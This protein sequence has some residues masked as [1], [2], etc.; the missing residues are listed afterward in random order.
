MNAWRDGRVVSAEEHAAW[1]DRGRLLGHGV[2]S[3][4]L[5]RA[6][7]GL[8][9]E[10]H[11]ARLSG[12]AVALGIGD[13]G[14]DAATVRAATRELWR[15]EGEPTRAALRI[16]VSAG[17]GRGLDGGG[18][19]SVVLSLSALPDRLP[20]VVAPSVCA[21]TVDA[22]RIDP[23]AAMSGHKTLSWMP[24]VL[25]RKAARAV[26]AD[27]GVI[28]TV[29]GDVACS[30]A[31]N[32]FVVRDG[33]LLTPALDRGVLPGITRA[34]VLALA[35]RVDS[36]SVREARLE[37]GE[38]AAADE[39]ILTSSLGPIAPV[40]RLDGRPYEAPGPVARW[41]AGC[42]EEDERLSAS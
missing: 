25:A 18:E 17:V 20:G 15:T 1:L 2:F 5:V 21:A 34:R 23:R 24:W 10:A 16:T 19:P 31:A 35:S 32:L 3:T 39:V 7:D 27:V 33:E 42:L 9:I 26:G 38:V 6:G 28:T 8:Y 41:L 29:D 40:G 13:I 14:I 12:S 37:P 4:L 11:M 30:D 36:P 22:H